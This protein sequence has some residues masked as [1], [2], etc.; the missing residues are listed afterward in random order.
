MT[1]DAWDDEER[2]E[3]EPVQDAVDDM[4]LRH[5]G[6]PP[7][8]ILSAAAGD[9][10]PPGWQA[11]VRAH[12]EHSAWSRALL[13]GAALP[14]EPLDAVTEAR[15]L[16]RVRQSTRGGGSGGTRVRGVWWLGL[17]GALAASAILAIALWPRPA[18]VRP[19]QARTSAPTESGLPAVDAPLSAEAALPQLPLDLP[20][21][22]APVEAL[23]WRGDGP[24]DAPYVA[25]LIPAYDAFRAGD[26][27]AA[28]L[29][30]RDAAERY[31]DAFEVLFYG[32]LSR[33]MLGRAEAAAA[34]FEAA[35]MDAVPARVAEVT[36]FLAV[37]RQ[38]AGQTGA[39]IEALR[40]ACDGEGAYA[41]RAC[42][43]LAAADAQPA[44]SR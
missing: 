5:A 2:T 40:T 29:A 8:D 4:R 26:H 34:S 14:P 9:A 21:L 17:G 31:P 25:A 33:L 12:L 30:F 6:T 44:V 22:Q 38:R 35:R 3:L 37:A 1:H 10:L 20:E 15:I 23:T 36:W 28:D 41:R 42:D 13:D 24:P 39:A 27:A 32:G 18:D 43:A 7:L 16:A 19:D 11:E